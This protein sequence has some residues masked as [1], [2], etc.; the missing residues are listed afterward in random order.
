[1]NTNGIDQGSELQYKWKCTRL[2]MTLTKWLQILLTTYVYKSGNWYPHPITSPPCTLGG[3]SWPSLCTDWLQLFWR[4]LRSTHGYLSTFFQGVS[5]S[6]SSTVHLTVPKHA[7]S[8][9]IS[10]IS[11]QPLGRIFWNPN[12]TDRLIQS[13]RTIPKYPQNSEESAKSRYSV[14]HFSRLPVSRPNR[15]KQMGLPTTWRESLNG[16]TD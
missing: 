7:I 9:R 2:Q 16:Q 6:T 15:A 3:L 4:L 12:R 1:M 10:R 14:H 13:F 5:F 11:P 8:R